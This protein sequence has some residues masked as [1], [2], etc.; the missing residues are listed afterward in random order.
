MSGNTFGIDQM[1][2]LLLGDGNTLLQSK[3]NRKG[4]GAV[5]SSTEM[6]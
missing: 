1:P 4:I 3:I 6:K 5:L 2:S